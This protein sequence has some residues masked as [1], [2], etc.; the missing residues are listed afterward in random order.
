MNTEYDESIVEA[1]IASAY[2]P[3]D[4]R[5]QLASA[6]TRMRRYRALCWACL[7]VIAVLVIRAVGA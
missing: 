7:L 4:L 3:E 5:D 6:E 1:L 2:T